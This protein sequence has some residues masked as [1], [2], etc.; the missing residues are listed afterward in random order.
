M[1]LTALLLTGVLTIVP[2]AGLAAENSLDDQQVKSKVSN[3]AV[4]NEPALIMKYL[5][6][7]LNGNG[8]SLWLENYAQNPSIIK[9]KLENLRK[10]V[11]RNKGI[12]SIGE[13]NIS[14][15][16]T[17]QDL[18]SGKESFCEAGHLV[19][20]NNQTKEG[21][22]KVNMVN[23]HG[24]IL[25]TD[26][27]LVEFAKD[28]R[29]YNEQALS[30]K[31]LAVEKNDYEGFMQDCNRYV[32]MG[33]DKHVFD[34]FCFL[35]NG[36]LKLVDVKLCKSYG[37]SVDGQAVLFAYNVFGHKSNDKNNYDALSIGVEKL[38]DGYNI[39]HLGSTYV[40]PDV[41]ILRS[42][43]AKEAAQYIFNEKADDKAKALFTKR[44]VSVHS[45]AETFDFVRRL[46][47]NRRYIDM[48][49]ASSALVMF[50]TKSVGEKKELQ[51]HPIGLVADIYKVEFEGAA[52]GSDYIAIINYNYDNDTLKI[53]GFNINMLLRLVK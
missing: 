10:D 23:D 34:N 30:A 5:Q 13:A 46:S 39:V 43:L 15:S 12:V 52:N 40:D 24:K 14:G 29:I 25:L 47:G 17:M 48:D 51:L 6:D 19:T 28:A 53:E 37:S 44:A 1:K 7:D 33:M 9:V 11:K 42:K 49:Y 22:L 41:M 2:F 50:K 35:K 21:F 20:F 31:K 27:T 38:R 45:S 18:I 36:K 32:L 26:V 8:N 4:V 16:K 3:A